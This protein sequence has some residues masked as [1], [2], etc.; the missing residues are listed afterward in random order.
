MFASPKVARSVS[1]EDPIL[2]LRLDL[3][4]LVRSRLSTIA[5]RPI[6]ETLAAKPLRI[7][8]HHREIHAVC[9]LHRVIRKSAGGNLR[10]NSTS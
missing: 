5:N 1:A 4:I 10:S 3:R 2:A 7:A 8:T 6:T 9:S